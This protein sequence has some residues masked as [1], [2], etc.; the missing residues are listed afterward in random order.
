M[1]N[2]RRY[3][4]PDSIVFITTI[5][6][7]REPLLLLPEYYHIF[8]HTYEKVQKL[9]PFDLIAYVILPDHFHWLVRPRMEVSNFTSLMHSFKRNYTLNLKR[10]RGIRR[11]IQ[12]WQEGFWDHVI[13]NQKDLINHIEYIRWNPIKH[14]H[15]RRPEEWPYSSYPKILDM[16]E[17]F[18]TNFE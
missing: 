8:W 18:P 9:Y 11:S 10:A 5:T 12:F 4:I 15:V 16:E 2:I 17:R 3:Y 14:G 7:N 13:R 6:R 1:S